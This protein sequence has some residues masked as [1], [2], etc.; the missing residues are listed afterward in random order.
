M[1]LFISIFS[2]VVKVIAA[3]QKSQTVLIE[4]PE[5]YGFSRLETMLNII[6]ELA[7]VL[8]SYDIQ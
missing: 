8:Y 5:L 6:Y 1:F 7:S 4:C 2:Y 3:L